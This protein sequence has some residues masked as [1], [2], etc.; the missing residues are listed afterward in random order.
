ML[1][2]PFEQDEEAAAGRVESVL[3][4]MDPLL[5]STDLASPFGPS[6]VS[7]TLPGTQA[8]E[9]ESIALTI[10]EEIRDMGDFSIGVASA[11]GDEAQPIELFRHCLT[12]LN[13]ARARGPNE[14]VLWELG[15]LR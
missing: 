10:L 15:C 13:Q 1:I 14:V 4:R 7:V 9:A 3:A 2:A 12:A 6:L 5:R 8:A 11:G